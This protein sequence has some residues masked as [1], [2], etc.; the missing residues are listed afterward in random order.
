MLKKHRYLWGLLLFIATWLLLGASYIWADRQPVGGIPQGLAAENVMLTTSDGLNLAA[1]WVPGSDRVVILLHGRGGDRTDT[2][3]RARFLS[4]AGYSLLMMDFRACGESEG[5]RQS[6]G[7]YE[8]EDVRTAVAW[9]RE[10]VPQAHIGILGVSK[11]A[12][13]TVFSRVDVDALVLESLYSDLSQAIERRFINRLGDGWGK[14]VA[15]LMDWQVPVFLGVSLE[16]VRPVDYIQTLS[17]P[18]LFVIGRQ[19]RLAL[20]GSQ[21]AM[22]NRS[23][24]E[25]EVWEIPGLGHVDFHGRIGPKY[26]KTILDFFNRT[27]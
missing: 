5:W 3:G 2:I 12:A 16:T 1:W 19:D 18:T 15:S 13:A 4:K 11:G 9:V 23:I 27:L 26:E 24:V 21:H 25:T 7:Y 6:F 10:Q 17:A 20:P 14:L 8:A 22:A